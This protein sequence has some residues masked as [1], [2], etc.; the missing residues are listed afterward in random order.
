MTSNETADLQDMSGETTVAPDSERVDGLKSIW[1]GVTLVA[2]GFGGLWLSFKLAGNARTIL[3][4][5][6]LIGGGMIGYGA[7]QAALGSQLP[8]LRWV[9]AAIAAVVSIGATIIVLE[10]TAGASFA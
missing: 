3:G 9:G 8:A 7:V 5:G 10:V 6:P 4:A 2:L 1:S